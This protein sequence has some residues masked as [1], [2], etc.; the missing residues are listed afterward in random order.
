MARD[1]RER[2]RTVESICQQYE[3]TVRPMAETFV[4]PQRA[5]ADVV[6]SGTQSI[7]DSVEAVHSRLMAVSY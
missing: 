2:G 5:F 6:V 7:Q 3:A 1:T 4:W